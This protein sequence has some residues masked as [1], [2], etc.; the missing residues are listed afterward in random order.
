MGCRIDTGWRRIH[1]ETLLGCTYVQVLKAVPAKRVFAV[2]T[3]HLSTAFVALDINPAH[4]ALLNGGFC[5]RPKEGPRKE[6][7]EKL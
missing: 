1:G 6:M 4:W 3:H 7:N 2:F 5:L